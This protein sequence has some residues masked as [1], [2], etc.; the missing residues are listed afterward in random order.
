MKLT[1]A[2]AV[3]FALLATSCAS[4]FRPKMPSLASA[5][6]SN[7]FD[8]YEIRRV[9]LLPFHGSSLSLTEA[10]ELQD[11]FLSEIS[12]ATPYEVVLLDP[13]NIA[14]VDHSNPH[15][16]GW[17]SPRTVIE[18][19][20]RYNLDAVLF[21]TV[22]EERHFPPL[23]LSL[24]AD[25]VSCETGLVIWSSRVHLDANDPRVRDGLRA[26]FAEEDDSEAWRLALLSPER[27]S[28]FA[29]YQ[30]SSLL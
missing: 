2:I 10:D 20:K 30:V 13:R 7:D 3:G 29:A 16:R 23:R 14:R 8:T 22:T 19:S 25:L 12:R 18:V 4:T 28:R 24:T 6:V 15:Q 9:G 11:A 1:H 17:Y 5:Q 26:Y 27:F 21:G